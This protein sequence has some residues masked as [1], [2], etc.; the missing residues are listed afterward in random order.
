[1][2]GGMSTRI[3]TLSGRALLMDRRGATRYPLRLVVTFSWKDEIGVVQG[4]EGESRDLNGRGMY[5]NSK[6]IPPVGSAVEMNVLLPQLASLKRQAE[7]HAEGRVVRIDPVFSDSNTSGFAAMNHTAMFR[8]T[9][10]HAI[11]DQH[12]WTQFGLGE[13]KI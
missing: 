3:S 2:T 1:M 9:E 6:L 11:D 8:D 7:L 10:G 12:S 13:T 4:G 5:V